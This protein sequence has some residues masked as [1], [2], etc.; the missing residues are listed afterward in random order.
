[1]I[2]RGAQLTSINIHVIKCNLIMLLKLGLQMT[3]TPMAVQ[4]TTTSMGRQT[5]IADVGWNITR[6]DEKTEKTINVESHGT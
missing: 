6:G 3:T 4:E 1:M 2:P 5:C